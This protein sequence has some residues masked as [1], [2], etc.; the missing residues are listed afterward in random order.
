[1]PRVLVLAA[2]P[3]RR[4]EL[5]GLLDG[6]AVVDGGGSG[7]AEAMAL[8]R[9]D[10]VV[11]DEADPLA[12]EGPGPATVLLTDAAD[13]DAL[14]AWLA[15]GVRAV[16]PAHPSGAALRAAVAAAAAGLVALPPDLV[17][18]LVPAPAW[19]GEPAA[20]L[21]PREREVLAAVRDGFSNKEVARRLGVS[22]QTVKFHLSAIY[23][24]LDAASRTEA[25]T[26]AVR[27]GLIEL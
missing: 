16:L 21:T 19:S 24:K 2:D 18:L 25:V 14:G 12:G 4:R 7:L 8:H 27:Q 26:R 6:S 5:A 9:P 10:V 1:M 11:L 23:A 15:A 17:E 22:D 13:A 3:A 20:A